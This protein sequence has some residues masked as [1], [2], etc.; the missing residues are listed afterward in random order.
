[1]ELLQPSQL[2]VDFGH[3]LIE[4]S[5]HLVVSAAEQ[6]DFRFAFVE[7]FEHNFL[8]LIGSEVN[9]RMVTVHRVV[10]PANHA[11]LPVVCIYD[12]RIG[13][14]IDIPIAPAIF[15]P[16]VV[17]VHFRRQ[18]IAQFFCQLL[19]HQREVVVFLCRSRRVVFFVRI[20]IFFVAFRFARSAFHG[21]FGRLFFIFFYLKSIA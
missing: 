11:V 21:L 4:D 14:M 15:V 6:S 3:L 17:V 8:P 12:T 19:S 7:V 9:L 2:V 5:L 16:I 10:E 18:T 13:I 1:M 20:Y